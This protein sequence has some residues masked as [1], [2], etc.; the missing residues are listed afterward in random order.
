MI[1][2][3]Y[4]GKNE[5]YFDSIDEIISK[6][7]NELKEKCYL[8]GCKYDG[9]EHDGLPIVISEERALQKAKEYNIPLFLT[10]SLTG[11]GISNLFACIYELIQE[12]HDRMNESSFLEYKQS[13]NKS[14][15]SSQSKKCIIV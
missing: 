11:N 1:L 7:P 4:D 8:I 14:S 6:I 12:K 3:C 13:L 10:S 5:R 2:I 9:G 15:H